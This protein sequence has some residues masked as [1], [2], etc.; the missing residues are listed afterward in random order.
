MDGTHN[1]G[2]FVELLRS[3]CAQCVA[4]A[5]Y[6]RHKAERLWFQYFH[7]TEERIGI[8]MPTTIKAAGWVKGGR[9]L[10]SD[11]RANIHQQQTVKLEKTIEAQEEKM[12]RG[13]KRDCTEGTSADYSYY[14]TEE[15]RQRNP[16]QFSAERT[17]ILYTLIKIQGDGA[18]EKDDADQYEE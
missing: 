18:T 14:W 7:W 5:G 12:K 1:L 17:S 6:C 9:V 16:L 2:I 13:V 4:G 3:Y 15:K 8:D 11:V 10:M